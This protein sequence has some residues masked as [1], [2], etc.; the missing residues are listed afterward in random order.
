MPG[1]AGTAGHIELERSIESIVVGIRHR[2]DLGDI[3]ALMR[4][5]D[6]VGLLQP[7]TIT[8]DGVLVCGWRRLEAARRLGLRTLNVWVRSGIS[9]ELSHVL[10][11][12]AENELRKPLNT[13]EA[14]RLYREVKLL[15]EEDAARR[16]RATRFGAP[17]DSA[18]RDGEETG[19]GQ[20]PGP[21]GSG[22]SRSEAAQ[23][24]VGNNGYHRLEKVGWLEDVRDDATRP[25][26]VRKLAAEALDQIEKGGPVDPPYKRVRAADR[27]ASA[28]AGPD[29]DVEDALGREAAEA[30]KRVQNPGRREGA[31][32][33][34]HP[35]G[36]QF[37]TPR[38]FV[39]TWTEL[40]G[41][42]QWYDANA[43]AE[44]ISDEEWER[45]ERVVAE[46][47][48]FAG[49]VRELRRSL[50]TSA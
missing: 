39:L 49:H 22:D 47:V 25:P 1:N 36:T 13:L 33:R 24:V 8:P 46:S 4:S 28:P 17:P 32:T 38:S 42:T 6:E 37:R 7:V 26:S 14:A 20:W 45:F 16:Q 34:T 27:L 30:L 10:A 35:K 48:E 12:Q 9:D 3:N 19:P 5:I 44:Q 43:I 40:D 2:K 50:A 21:S 11:Q 23:L 18:G 15:K 31:A 41:W 29:P